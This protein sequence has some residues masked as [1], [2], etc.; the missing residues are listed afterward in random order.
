VVE[1]RGGEY[2]RAR[3]TRFSVACVQFWPHSPMTVPERPR[4][5]AGRLGPL[6]AL[7][8]LIGRRSS[9]HTPRSSSQAHAA[10][11]VVRVAEAV[12]NLPQVTDRGFTT[13]RRCQAR[14]ALPPGGWP[15]LY[16]ACRSY[17]PLEFAAPKPG[18]C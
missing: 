9:T 10:A 4:R 8:P 18:T 17:S 3:E 1:G 2:H 13:K 5:S 16:G 15:S 12:H 11:V 7:P 6:Q 14:S